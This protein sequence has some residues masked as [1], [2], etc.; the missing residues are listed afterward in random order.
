MEKNNLKSR[1]L[2]VTSACERALRG[3]LFRMASASRARASVRFIVVVLAVMTLAVLGSGM[4]VPV[5]AAPADVAPTGGKVLIA[6]GNDD[7]STPLSSELYDPAT[8]S[9]A[10]AADTASMNADRYGATVVLLPSG[11]VLIVGGKVL[12]GGG[13]ETPCLRLNSTIL[14]RT[15]SPPPPIL[16]A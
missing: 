9:F 1:W 2:S 16:R 8:N 7:I 12:I 10:A 13:S 14:R 3:S 6:G 5:M 4:R 11:K 15:P